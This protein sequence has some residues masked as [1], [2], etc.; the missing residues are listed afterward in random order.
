MR[1]NMAFKSTEEDVCLCCSTVFRPISTIS[2]QWGFSENFRM[3]VA[4]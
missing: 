2:G 4:S 3:V 1:N